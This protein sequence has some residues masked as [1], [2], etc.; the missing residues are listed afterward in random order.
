VSV[1]LFS[2]SSSLNFI[3]N[4]KPGGPVVIS[5]PEINRILQTLHKASPQV[6]AKP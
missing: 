6:V 4:Q 3:L 1:R 2:D 5:Q